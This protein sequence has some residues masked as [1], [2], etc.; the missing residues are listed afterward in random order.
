LVVGVSNAA[1]VLLFEHTQAAAHHG[2]QHTGIDEEDFAF[3][4][5]V[6]AIPAIFI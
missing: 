3:T 2:D 6:L 1:E 4:L 5:P